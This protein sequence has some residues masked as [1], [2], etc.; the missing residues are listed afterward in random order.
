M[1]TLGFDLEMM[2]LFDSL[3]INLNVIGYGIS[4]NLFG[5]C[6]KGENPSVNLTLSRG[7]E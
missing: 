4:S 6:Y 1:A 5:M 2:V 7:K 3:V